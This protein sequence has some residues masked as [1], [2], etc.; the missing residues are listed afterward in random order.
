VRRRTGRHHRTRCHYSRDA[1]EGLVVGTSD[2]YR[3]A[4]QK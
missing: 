1:I 2:M 4:E 3:K